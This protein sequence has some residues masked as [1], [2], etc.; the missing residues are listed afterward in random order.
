MNPEHRKRIEQECRD[1][2]TALVHHYDH[3]EAEQA[4]ALFVEDGLWVKSQ[5]PYQGRAAIIS[6][7]AAQPAPLVLR[8][9]TSNILVTV[10]DE[11]RA[12]AVTYYLAFVGQRIQTNPDAELPLELPGSLGEW[13][14]SFVATPEGWRF[15]RREGRRIFGR[16]ASKP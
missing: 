1:L 16:R 4:A 14:D 6:S 13:N 7:F 8:H 15:T 9:F 10:H 11:R 2:I 3:G 12:S 5:V